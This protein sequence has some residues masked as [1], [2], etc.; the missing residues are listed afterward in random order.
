MLLY[1]TPACLLNR[2]EYLIG[3]KKG[4]ETNR[5]YSVSQSSIKIKA[6]KNDV[7]GLRLIAFHPIN[8]MDISA[9][10]Q[11]SSQEHLKTFCSGA[12]FARSQLAAPSC[13][14]PP[15]AR[16]TLNILERAH[17]ITDPPQK[18]WTSYTYLYWCLHSD[19]RSLVSGL[20]ATL[21]LSQNK[22]LFH[23]CMVQFLHSVAQLHLQMRFGGRSAKPQVV[24]RE[25]GQNFLHSAT[26]CL[27]R[28]VNPRFSGKEKPPPV[29]PIEIQ[30]SISPSSA[31]EL[32]MTSALANYATEA[33]EE[34][35]PTSMAAW[36]NA[37]LSCWIRLPK[38]GR[39]RL[40]DSLGFI[41]ADSISP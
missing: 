31:V 30:T 24:L 40:D 15:T 38:M 28:N 22:I 41:E 4:Q 1:E 39:S 32:N 13:S 14:R 33:E 10:I 20:S 18:A 7:T 17:N 23:C 26:H 25:L 8:Q 5:V 6:E 29:H 2:C 36:F 9:Y 34:E 37:L 16:T 3:M 21:I 35:L 19:S 11:A 12:Q 27:I